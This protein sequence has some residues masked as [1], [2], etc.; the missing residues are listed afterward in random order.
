[1]V[2]RQLSQSRD[3]LYGMPEIKSSLIMTACHRSTLPW[4]HTLN[5]MRRL[6][7]G[8]RSVR[9]HPTGMHPAASRSSAMDAQRADTKPEL[10]IKLMG[11]CL[12]DR[13]SAAG[14]TALGGPQG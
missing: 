4:P 2:R 7:G 9:C 1:M 12:T 13:A 6:R 10:G 11:C 5:W 3:I 8:V 14:A